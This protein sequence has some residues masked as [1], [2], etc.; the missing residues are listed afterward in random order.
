MK[1]IG[2]SGLL[3]TKFV[4]FPME[5]NRHLALAQ[6]KLLTDATRYRRLIGR[7]IYLT[8]TRPDLTYIVHILSQFMQTPREEHMD[9]ARQVLHYLKGTVGQG[10]LLLSDSNLQPIGF[11][12]LDWGA[13]PIS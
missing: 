4:T 13:C 1:I 8:I 9:A 12:D 2:E 11:C 6:G 7:L 5:Q 3:G 10:T